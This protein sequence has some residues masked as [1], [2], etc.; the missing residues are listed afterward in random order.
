MEKKGGLGLKR[1][2]G[3]EQ[4]TREGRGGEQ[5]GEGEER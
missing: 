3:K 4:E 5:K 1:E 2:G